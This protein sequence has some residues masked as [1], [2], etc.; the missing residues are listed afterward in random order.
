M[1]K[2]VLEAV[3]NFSE[4]RSTDVIERIVDAFVAAGADVLDWSADPDHN[5][6][7]VTFVGPPDVVEEAAVAGAAI[8]LD[9]IDLRRHQGVHPRVGVIDVLPF[10][11]LSGLT[12]EDARTSAHRVGR[13]LAEELGVPVSFYAHASDPPGRRLAA[14][15]RGGFEALADAWPADR[16]PDL[17]P[18]G[19]SHPGAHPSAGMVCVGARPLM[20]AWNVAVEG[21]R[22]TEAEHIAAGIRERGGGFTGLRALALELPTRQTVQI[23]MNLEDLATTSPIDILRRIEQMAT[24]RGGRVIGTEVIGMVPDE[25]VL[26]AADERLQTGGLTT[27][28]LLSRRLAEHLAKRT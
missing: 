27:R 11:P 15:R 26:S 14:L 25:L 18:P 16:H 22:F 5:R 20:L 17:L 6:T 23:S 24:D 28:R 19:W 4:G 1:T 21:L 3:P 7:V 13:V 8:A 12:L 10:V 9:R 2:R